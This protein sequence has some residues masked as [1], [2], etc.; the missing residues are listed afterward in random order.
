MGCLVRML[1]LLVLLVAVA[2][3]GAA[4]VMA[5]EQAPLIERPARL[6]LGDLRQA[7]LLAQRYDP[8]R[9]DPAKITTVTASEAELNTVLAGSLVGISPAAARVSVTQRG[10][11]A[12]TTIALPVPANPIG[13]YVNV[14]LTVA[15]SQQ[16]LDVTRFAVGRVEL[17]A[18]LVLPALRLTLDHLVGDGKGGPIVDSIRS[19]RVAGSVVTVAFRPPPKLVEDIKTAAVRQVR[20][21]DPRTVQV[22]WKR[23]S[24]QYD[25]T[26]RGG[27]V[28]LADFLRPT[29]AVARQRSETRDAVREN[30]AALI[31]VAMFFGDPRFERFVGDVLT[32]AQRQQRRGTEHVR[33]DGRH[34]FVQ[35]F[36]I[37]A[38]LTLTGGSAA[39]DL[40]GELKEVKD[41]S[42]K[43]GFSFTDIGA[44]RL[45]VRF[46]R[47]A[48]A[49]DANARRF[50]D[51]LSRAADEQAF[52]P[53]LA[54][55]PEGMSEAA[56]RSRY[57]DIGSPAYQRVIAEIDRR[58]D[59]I[60]LYR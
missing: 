8:R 7:Q 51:V 50:Q 44:D 24:E 49:S 46:A 15:P 17:P 53:G 28:S 22:Y 60:G 10:V 21:S 41:S 1:L 40:I 6:S 34:D 35:H 59:S 2:L 20:I 12:G 47:R 45:G 31:A 14:R 23:L 27:R 38:G 52:F 13:R 57:G 54:D 5:V 26:P 16:G 29:F 19:V 42:Q 36:A 56:F 11:L 30:E 25:R 18:M 55:L 33:L 58:I 37:S 4:I 39:A 32:P 3:P 43:S 48:V 9:M